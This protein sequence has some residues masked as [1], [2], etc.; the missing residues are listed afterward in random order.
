MS[1]LYVMNCKKQDEVFSYRAPEGALITQHIPK[2]GQIQVYRDESEH[3][4][5][6]IVEQHQKYG[7]IEACNIDRT[8]PFINLAFQF[9]K[10]FTPDQ[11]MRGMHH[12]IDVLTGRGAEQRVNS[13]VGINDGLGK[14]AQENGSKVLEMDLTLEDKTEGDTNSGLDEKLI[15]APY[16]S[17]KEHGQRQ[18]GRPARM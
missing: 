6:E 1:K 18:K 8:K 3:V 2:G 12:N 17:K 4:L 9:D 11:I 10:P 7:V 16:I 15:V 5:R 14:L 13:A